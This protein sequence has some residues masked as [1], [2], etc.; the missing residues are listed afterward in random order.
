MFFAFDFLCK[1]AV[2][3]NAILTR[4]VSVGRV[5]VLR[6]CRATK[7]AISLLGNSLSGLKNITSSD[8]LSAKPYGVNGK[9]TEQL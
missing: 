2:I 8:L 3:L 4:L 1:L 6:S 5:T 7:V 9:Q